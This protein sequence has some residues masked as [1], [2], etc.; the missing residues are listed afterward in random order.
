ML[1]LWESSKSFK[2]DVTGVLDITAS[3]SILTDIVVYVS[4]SRCNSRLHIS[5]NSSFVV[6]KHLSLFLHPFSLILNFTVLGNLAT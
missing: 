5:L 2:R 3:S 1:Q 6:V 4:I